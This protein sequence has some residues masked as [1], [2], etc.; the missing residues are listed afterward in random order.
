[1]DAP[2]I[3]LLS[4]SEQR[5]P[6]ME[7]FKRIIEALITI[8]AFLALFKVYFYLNPLWKRKHNIE[9]ARSQSIVALLLNLYGTTLY[10][11]LFLIDGNIAPAINQALFMFQFFII[12]LIG[13]GVWVR[14]N[15]Q[16]SLISLFLQKLNLEAKESGDLAKSLI[17]P[18]QAGLLLRI[19]TGFALIDDDL[20]PQ[21]QEIID[22]LAARW[23]ISFHW[24]EEIRKTS[25][26]SSN[27]FLKL[28]QDVSDYLDSSPP[29]AEVAELLDLIDTLIKSD[30]RIEE[31]EKLMHAEVGGLFRGY[32]AQDPIEG[33]HYRVIVLPAN[34]EQKNA[35]GSVMSGL[36]PSAIHEFAYQTC[37]FY[38]Q[39]F[40]ECICEQYQRFNLQ[41]YVVI[42]Q[43]KTSTAGQR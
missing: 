15:R 16:E 28:R 2:V 14:D 43:T 4:G 17:K 13:L 1:M 10:F 20:S 23:H 36:T 8:N 33:D 21:E 37:I 29:S 42:E 39:G 22:A 18:H 35:I 5:N 12:I 41:S 27:R 11:L 6:F 19:L 26:V 38:S 40:A 32:L 7:T 25:S 24:N 3:L 31:S 34:Q 30:D 9:V